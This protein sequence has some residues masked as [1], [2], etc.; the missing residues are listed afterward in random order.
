MIVEN[1][2]IINAPVEVVWNVT[3]D[4]ENWPRWTP[5]VTNVSRLDDGPFKIGSVAH[6]KQPG[7]P[8]TQWRVTELRE[9]KGFT[10]E[11]RIYGMQMSATHDLSALGSQTESILRIEI[12]GILATLL[13]PLIRSSAKRNLERENTG[14]QNACEAAIAGRIG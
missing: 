3:T 13:W 7:L 1:T 2:K 10:W 14:L 4:I 9:G 11:T 12:S 6:I 5:T 8:E